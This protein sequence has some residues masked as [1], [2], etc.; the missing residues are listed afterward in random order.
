MKIIK[1]SWL[2]KNLQ[3]FAINPFIFTRNDIPIAVLAHEMVHIER[4]QAMGTTKWLFKYL[5]NRQFRY[6]EE[7]E[8]LKI[9]LKNEQPSNPWNRAWNMSVDLQELYRLPAIDV[10]D[11]TNLIL[12]NPTKDN[13]E[14]LS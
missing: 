8:A 12:S 5:T 9:Q 7:V 1:A 2:P 10:A 4:Q 11:T 3:A 6:Q 14:S 13:S